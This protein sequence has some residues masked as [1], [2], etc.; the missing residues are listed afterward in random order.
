[1]TYK[2]K[3]RRTVESRS[4]A[5]AELLGHL[6]TFVEEE[7][8]LDV[9]AAP[10]WR[11]LKQAVRDPPSG[12]DLLGVEDEIDAYVCAYVAAYHWTHRTSRCRVVGDAASG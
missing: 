2:A 1:L 5:L 10:R 6:E 7:P 3:P 9:T 11:E 4:A 12:A 8:P